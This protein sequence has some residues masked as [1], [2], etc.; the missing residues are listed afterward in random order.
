MSFNSQHVMAMCY[1]GFMS[2]FENKPHSNRKR[3]TSTHHI[4][5]ICRECSCKINTPPIRA[6]D[7]HEEFYQLNLHKLQE[8]MHSHHR[9]REK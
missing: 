5:E 1:P 7:I 3:P 8:T 9:E 6:T 4:G 2:A